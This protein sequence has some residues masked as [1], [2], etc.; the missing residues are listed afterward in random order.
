MFYMKHFDRRPRLFRQ[1]VLLMFLALVLSTTG[2]LL[3][4]ASDAPAQK[5]IVT[6]KSV[7]RSTVIGLALRSIGFENAC[8]TKGGLMGLMK[9]LSPKTAS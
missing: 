6:C 9:Y 8:T 3:A 7:V 1:A 5:V 2:D 4:Q